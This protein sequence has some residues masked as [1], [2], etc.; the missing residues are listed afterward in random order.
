MNAPVQSPRERSDSVEII[1]LGCRLNAYESEA[2]RTLTRDAPMALVI[3]PTDLDEAPSVF[4][5]RLRSLGRLHR[6]LSPRHT[7]FVPAERPAPIDAAFATR[8]ASWEE[9]LSRVEV[10]GRGTVVQQGRR[11]VA[12][13]FP[14]LPPDL[15]AESIALDRSWRSRPR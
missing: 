15:Q 8:I 10:D 13:S 2:M 3:T 12:G 7:L 6:A 9:C 1:T 11:E 4:W 5:F 14:D